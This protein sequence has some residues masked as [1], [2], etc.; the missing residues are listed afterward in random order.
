MKKGML[1]VLALFVVLFVS[2]VGADTQAQTQS[3][4]ADTYPVVVDYSQSLEQMIVASHCSYSEFD[5]NDSR[6]FRFPGWKSGKVKVNLQLIQLGRVVSTDEVR[7]E[8]NRRNL[9]PATLPELLAFATAYPEMQRQFPIAALS[10]FIEVV[11]KDRVDC[12]GPVC[13]EKRAG[14]Y[15][16]TSRLSYFEDENP[17]RYILIRND[18]SEWDTWCDRFRFL[19]VPK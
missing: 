16:Y 2:S 7:A 9:R 19:A 4:A 13:V 6:Q 12:D 5:I 17:S 11:L 14:E 3:V 1:V 18:N 15:S 8:M 10:P